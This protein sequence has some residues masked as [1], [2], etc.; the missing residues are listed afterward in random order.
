MSDEWTNHYGIQITRD[1][2]G[3][4]DI[5]PTHY[6]F[7]S[8][9]STV[10]IALQGSGTLVVN[11]SSTASVSIAHG[12][13]FIPMSMVFV[14]LEPGTGQWYLGENGAVGVSIYPDDIYTN[15]TYL[16]ISLTNTSGS[17]KTVSYYAYIFADDGR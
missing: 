2:Y 16:V 10:K 3:I 5:D 15:A 4:T 1:G 8:A 6:A 12:L 13:P 17:Q 14:E 9:Y 7:N 11:G